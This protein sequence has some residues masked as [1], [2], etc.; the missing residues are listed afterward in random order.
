MCGLIELH[1]VL[2]VGTELGVQVVRI[3]ASHERAIANHYGVKKLPTVKL[4][5]NG[6]DTRTY[7]GVRSE[8][9][10]LFWVRSLAR[11]PVQTADTVAA[12]LDVVRQVFPTCLGA[13]ADANATRPVPTLPK[14]PTPKF[15][16][17]GSGRS[18]FP[19]S[20]EGSDSALVTLARSAFIQELYGIFVIVPSGSEQTQIISAIQSFRG[21]GVNGRPPDAL[22]PTEPTSGSL[23]T[24]FPTC[25]LA[26]QAQAT[27]SADLDTYLKKLPADT[28]PL[29]PRLDLDDTSQLLY[30]S[31]LP[32]VSIFGEGP[33]VSDLSYLKDGVLS[34]KVRTGFLELAGKFYEQARFGYLSAAQFPLNLPVILGTPPTRYPAAAIL[35]VEPSGVVAFLPNIILLYQQY[36]PTP[37]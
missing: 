28:L 25:R 33:P 11:P 31:G 9:A 21:P 24:I 8:D 22:L 1:V 23:L 30:S 14:L 37:A 10:I 36:W 20:P 12:A 27:I 3:D 17:I 34:R 6:T 18:G 29:L 4:F 2:P 32:I 7:K 15:V 5:V 16:S 13:E 19:S 35:D 26:S